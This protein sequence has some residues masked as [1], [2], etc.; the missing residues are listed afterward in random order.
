MN[1]RPQLVIA[2]SNAGK[3]REFET[4]LRKLPLS[5]LS[6]ETFPDVAM[7]QE[8]DDYRENALRK[9]G[10][11]ARAT[12]LPALADDSGLEVAALGGA[13]GPGSAR[14]GGPDL[15]D[16]GRLERLLAELAARGDPDRNA[17]FVC[18]AALALPSGAVFTALGTCRGSL[19]GAPRG[20][21]GF[22]Y[23]PIFQPEGHGVSMAEL[24]PERKNEISHRARSLAALTPDLR[25]ELLGGT[26]P[27]I[28][29]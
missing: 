14:Y 24:P 1:A 18:V 12:G 17:R 15:D 21:A 9:A 11:V 3:L 26:A 4:L 25:R 22:G 27:R 10:S 16:A 6:L 23:D 13:P 2:T 29:P 5:L 7:P 8:G 28:A 20:V 19:L